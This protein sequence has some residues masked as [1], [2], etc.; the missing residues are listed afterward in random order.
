MSQEHASD[1][2]SRLAEENS[3]VPPSPSPFSIC[4]PLERGRSSQWSAVA[5]LRL[6]ASEVLE[7]S[8]VEVGGSTE[9]LEARIAEQDQTILDLQRRLAGDEGS[10]RPAS[11]Q[12]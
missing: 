6:N 11:A 12:R 2:I 7:M 3:L 8:A 9:A 10:P 1:E 5:Q 4:P